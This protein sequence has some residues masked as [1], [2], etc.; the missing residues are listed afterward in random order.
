MLGRRQVGKTTLARNIGESRPSTYLDLESE[1]DRAKLAEPE[2]YLAR[3]YNKLVFR[4]EVHRLPNAFQILRCLIHRNRPAGRR[5]G[6]FLLLGYASI[7]L[8]QSGEALARRIAYLGMQ[9][10]DGVEVP[11]H[12][13]DRL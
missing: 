3:H 12:T 2:L 8:K 11:D 7:D 10:V 6:E 1:A 4:D 13:L 5:T 9:P